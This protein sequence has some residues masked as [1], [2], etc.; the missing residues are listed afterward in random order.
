MK[1]SERNHT[2][3]DL[4]FVTLLEGHDLVTNF[5]C[6][7]ANE[8]PKRY[9]AFAGRVSP[10]IKFPKIEPRMNLPYAVG[11][12]LFR[13]VDMELSGKLDLGIDA[14]VT[15]KHFSVPFLRMVKF[16]RHLAGATPR[17]CHPLPPL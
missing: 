16:K 12:I 13:R 3:F 2:S 8:Y 14:Q 6:P 5:V 15:I 4:H 11:T 17:R 1:G 10:A 7:T 9:D